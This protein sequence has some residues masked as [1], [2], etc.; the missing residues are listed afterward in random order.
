MKTELADNKAWN[1]ELLLYRAVKEDTTGF[2]DAALYQYKAAL[3]QTTLGRL[4]QAKDSAINTRYTE[5]LVTLNTIND[6]LEIES[7]LKT[8][9]GFYF[10]KNNQTDS[11]IELSEAEIQVLTELAIE[12]PYKYG[13]AVYTARN[14]LY[15]ANPDTLY[16]NSCEESYLLLPKSLKVEENTTEEEKEHFVIYPNPSAGEFA[17][18]FETVE[19]AEKTNAVITDL[20]GRKMGEFTAFRG[21]NMILI[22]ADALPKGVYFCTVYEDGVMIKTKQIQKL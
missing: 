18:V 5:A 11:T 7:K 19:E 3:E 2:L 16:V 15:G 22:P 13:E 17:L 1:R 12:C 4:E 6:T 9:L 14:I 21:S 20:Y 8:V 10:E